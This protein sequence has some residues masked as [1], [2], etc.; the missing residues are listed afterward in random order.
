M[1]IR[2]ARSEE[3][4][5]LWALRN[6]ALRHGCKNIYSDRIL[7]AWTPEQMPV[8]YRQIIEENPFY[9]IDDEYGIP[10]ASGFLCL[11]EQ[12]VEAVFSLPEHSGKGLASQIIEAIKQQA[13]SRGMTTLRLSSTPNARSF[14]EKHGFKMIREDK[15]YSRLAA[16]SLAC[17]EM[18]CDLSKP[19]TH[20]S[21]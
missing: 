8:S 7:Q 14:Y 4:E 3:A 21:A 2:Y 16:S 12:S 5:I 17:F 15:Y 20:V 1:T 13:L 11:S 10:V 19:N 18:V 9:V 6:C